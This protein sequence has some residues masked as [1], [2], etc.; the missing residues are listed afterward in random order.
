MIGDWVQGFIPETQSQIVGIS[1]HRVSIIGGH[2]Y[3]EA[4]IDDIQPI[5]LTPEILEKNGFKK[6]FDYQWKYRD[7]GCKIVISIAPQ[8]K[9]E[10]EMLGETPIN[11][12]LEGALFD[13]NITSD[14]Y[15]HTLQH[16]LRLCGITL[17]IKI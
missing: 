4:S 15:V 1:E 7:N 5:P 10:G 14:C 17:N 2:T 11:I 12:M 13:I 6:Q 16:I 9:I 3:M 8:I